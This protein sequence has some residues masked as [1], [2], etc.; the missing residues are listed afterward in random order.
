MQSSCDFLV[1]RL[2]IGVRLYFFTDNSY[3]NR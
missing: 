1:L 2:A 3:P